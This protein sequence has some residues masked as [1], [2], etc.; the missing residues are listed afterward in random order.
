MDV[1]TGMTTTEKTDLRDR[2]RQLMDRVG[3]AAERSGRS[4]EQVIV[5]A[6]TKAAA[7]EQI[8]QLVEM[9]HRDLGENRVQQ[10]T[11][12]VAMID[13]FLNRHRSMTSPRKVAVPDRVRW[14]LVGHLQRNKVKPILPLVRL[15]HSVDSMRLAEEVQGQAVK[16]DLVADVL[17]QVNAS[18][19]ANKHGLAPA[20][21]THVIDQMRSMPNVQVRG[22]MT[23]APYAEEPERA[24][25]IFQRAA[26]L[27]H[28][29]AASGAAGDRF[30]VLSMGMTNDFEVAIE[31]GANVVRVGRA[32]FGEAEAEADD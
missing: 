2:Y 25:P 24:R 27:F 3:A 11:Q 22:L 17:L 13:E 9:G 31:C 29:I 4:A 14:H 23:M 21:V 6:V 15:T 30:N 20:A 16:Q 8:R 10:L 19:E 28:D 32:L 26:E 12:R 1:G 5:V 18:G 7:P